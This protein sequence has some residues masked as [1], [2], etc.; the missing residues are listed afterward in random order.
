MRRLGDL[1]P[2]FLAL[3]SACA[4]YNM[5]ECQEATSCNLGPGGRCQASPGGNQLWCSYP[6]PEC[7]SGYRYSDSAIG[8]RE[9]VPTGV[10]AGVDAHVDAG[11]VDAFIAP[12]VIT[13]FSPDWGS[14]SGGTFV[15]MVG[16]GFTVPYLAV[17]F[18][19]SAASQVRVIS[20]T[21]LTVMTPVG[22]HAPV[23]VTVTTGGGAASSTSKFRY[24][25]PLYASDAR[26][27]TPGNLYIV[28]PANATSVAVGPLGVAVTGLALSPGGLLY[29]AT[30]I[31]G[32]PDTLIT[33]DP[34]TARVTT[35]GPLVTFTGEEAKSPDL[36]FEG[37]MLFGWDGLGLARISVTTGQVTRYNT[38][39]P[40]VAQSLVSASPGV[41]LIGQSSNLCTVNTTNGAINGCT[42]LSSAQFS[43]NALTFV[44]TTLY[45]SDPVSSTPK[46]TVLR[47][48]DIA[49]G[50]TTV[51]GT[52]PPSVDAL[53]GISAMGMQSSPVLL[54]RIAKPSDA[55]APPPSAEATFRLG[56]RSLALHELFALSSREVK[57]G[58]RVRRIIPL[59]SLTALGASDRLQLI[60]A[61]GDSRVV[62]LRAPGLA[63]TTNHRQELKLVDVREGFQQVLGAIVEVREAAPH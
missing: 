61:D 19:S 60:S 30:A 8:D 14:T 56:R 51:V 55:G 35:I 41:L 54:P 34:Y 47:T 40:T 27:T 52:L 46:V 36:S 16:F 1:V 32:L 50:A 25:A 37:T 58:V 38:Q 12:P 57:D 3:T 4:H 29:G 13:A 44:G 7:P 11:T 62:S 45:G 63:L 20:D 9:C 22:P 6:D 2:V 18:G 24:L 39:P 49:T 42:A 26:G 28:N 21:E 5:F 31:Q 53:A 10:D 59:A 48:I 33:I 17:R 15:R 23:D 43:A